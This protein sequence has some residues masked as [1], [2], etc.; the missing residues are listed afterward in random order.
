LSFCGAAEGRKEKKQQQQK[1]QKQ[2]EGGK[3]IIGT[4]LRQI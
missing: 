1:Q 3:K 2:K 4:A